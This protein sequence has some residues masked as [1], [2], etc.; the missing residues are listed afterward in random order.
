MSGALDVH[1]KLHRARLSAYHDYA[2]AS[3]TQ[4][5]TRL[6]K[7]DDIVARP[8]RDAARM[9]NAESTR[10]CTSQRTRTRAER[11]RRPRQ[12]AQHVSEGTVKSLDSNALLVEVD[13]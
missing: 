1:T 10:Q 13:N 5:R 7:K 8:Q 3:L 11:K 2:L 12:D 6:G 9:F 4:M